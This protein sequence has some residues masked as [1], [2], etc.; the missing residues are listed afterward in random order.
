[1]PVFA[2]EPDKFYNPVLGN[3]VAE[4]K[5]SKAGVD[6]M[7][8]YFKEHADEFRKEGREEFIINMYRK[9]YTLEQISDVTSKTPEEIKIIIIKSGIKQV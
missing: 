5:N 9:N 2:A 8:E 6:T 3:R 1:M 7:S 4:I